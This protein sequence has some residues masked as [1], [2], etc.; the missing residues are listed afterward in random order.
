MDHTFTHLLRTIPPLAFACYL[1][2][3]DESSSGLQQRLIELEAQRD[4]QSQ[5]AAELQT[6]L[7]GLMEKNSAP[8]A[9]GAPTTSTEDIGS[10]SDRAA[11]IA[12]AAAVGSE[13]AKELPSGALETFGQTEFAG[14]KLKAADGSFT[15]VL[16]PF[17]SK[18]DGYWESGWSREEIKA[19]LQNQ[20][21]K[22][23]PAA[24][25]SPSYSATPPPSPAPSGIPQSNHAGVYLPPQAAP[26]EV[27]STK[28]PNAPEPDAMALK[29]GEK[30]VTLTDLDGNP[31]KA[32]MKADGTLRV[33]FK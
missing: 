13:L 15:S 21:K 10:S 23:E 17:Y 33:I 30:V 5:K 1:C 22:T 31:Q 25:S 9:P 14:F 24:M 32:I 7:N 6:R 12:A 19:A 16:V 20:G 29:P 3:C 18:G 2:S 28:S 4:A 26:P 27:V 8:P 11:L